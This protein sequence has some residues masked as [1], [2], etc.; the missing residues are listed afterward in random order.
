MKLQWKRFTI[1]TGLAIVTIVAIFF[2]YVSSIINSLTPFSRH[3]DAIYWKHGASVTFEPIKKHRWLHPFLS[4]TYSKTIDTVCLF[5]PEHDGDTLSSVIPH[6]NEFESFR[7]L[8]IQGSAIT[9]DDLS[10]LGDLKHIE[11]LQLTGTNF[12]DTGLTHVARLEN[13]DCLVISDT[14]VTTNGLKNLRDALPYCAI[15]ADIASPPAEIRPKQQTK[16]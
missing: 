11:Q 1:R 7:Q 6:I 10:D 14:R 2:V 4:R 8:S 5:K 15:I 13:L 16:Q 9:D 3:Y 12:S